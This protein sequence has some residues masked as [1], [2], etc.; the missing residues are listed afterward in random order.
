MAWALAIIL[1]VVVCPVAA[2]PA[3]GSR[4]TGAPA[5]PVPRLPQL[6]S[7]PSVR[8]DRIPVISLGPQKPI[9]REEAAHIRRLI[10]SLAKIESGDYGL[11][12]TFTGTLFPP[13]PGL[14]GREPFHQEPA[15]PGS[16][17]ALRQLIE[18]G[19]R[20]LPF[21]L[22]ALDDRTPTQLVVRHSAWGAGDM[23]F[24]HGETLM[25]NNPL[26]AAEQKAL[27][28]VPESLR[29]ATRSPG[30][31]IHVPAPPGKPWDTSLAYTATIGD[32]CLVGIGQIVGRPYAAIGY[33]P[34]A[35][36]SIDSPSHDPALAY[37]VRAI[38]SSKNPAQHLL[39]SLLLDYS[40]RGIFDGKTLG[41]MSLGS[42]LQVEASIRLL[43]YFPRQSAP[44]IAARLGRLNVSAYSGGE[45]FIR[46]EASNEVSTNRFIQAATGCKEPAIRAAL[47]GIFRQTRDPQIVVSVLP[48]IS[49]E[50]APL[51]CSR[52]SAFLD[53]VPPYTGRSIG[54]EDDL[55]Y[56]CLQWGTKGDVKAVFERYL[57]GARVE[58]CH[59]VCSAF[60]A[61]RRPWDLDV[62]APLLN[63]RRPAGWDYP[64]DPKRSKAR[65]PVRV[66]DDAAE[67]LTMNHPDLPFKMA[68]THA[69]L[70]RQIEAIRARIGKLSRSKSPVRE[71]R[72]SEW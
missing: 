42:I 22:A 38:W 25:F 20:A 54:D 13:L 62:L 53:H 60:R 21:L 32:A 55:L 65:L 47:L 48:G 45:S 44:M 35:T 23:G 33:M 70:D 15:R 12:P 46:R 43:Y 9:G 19:P 31:L 24:A 10:A 3:K 63:D 26:N 50:H 68:G 8:L 69:D 7:S 40:T 52:L 71:P 16:S 28:S 34:T 72:D 67:T 61:V 27:A 41:S 1:A 36:V 4:T 11:S 6:S 49:Q 64:V 2:D 18:L 59:N 30:D 57:V 17:S 51:V 58:H 39:D 29:G 14:E 66:C 5:P 56:A 37:Q